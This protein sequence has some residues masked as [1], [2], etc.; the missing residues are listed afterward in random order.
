AR[1]AYWDHRLDL[2]HEAAIESAATA[3]RLVEEDPKSSP[4]LREA[5]VSESDLGRMEAAESRPERALGPYRRS[6]ELA[7]RA[8]ALA[9][10]DVRAASGWAVNVVVAAEVELE[11]GDSRQAHAELAPAVAVLRELLANDRDNL[12]ART[13]LAFALYAEC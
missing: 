8:R 12:Q 2:A 13:R 6:V 11:A 1:A 3:E 5:A 9:P 10:D 4:Y 7:A